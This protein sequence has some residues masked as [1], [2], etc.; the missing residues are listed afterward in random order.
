MTDR[1]ATI[2]VLATEIS[3]LLSFRDY[4]ND[5]PVPEANQRSIGKVVDVLVQQLGVTI[6]TL[7]EVVTSTRSSPASTVRPVAGPRNDDLFGAPETTEEEEIVA[8]EPP[9]APRRGRRGPPAMTGKA[10]LGDGMTLVVG[11]S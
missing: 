6:S 11:Q 2:S 7:A 1:T 10:N 4:L 5:T 9:Q 8:P 3:R